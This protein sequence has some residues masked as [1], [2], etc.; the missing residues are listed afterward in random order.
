MSVGIEDHDVD[1]AVVVE[2]VEGHA[3]AAHLEFRQVAALVRDVDKLPVAHVPQH[4]IPATVRRS[5]VIQLDVV[6]EVAADD[7]EVAVAIVVEIN[8]TTAPGDVGQR[9]VAGP[10]GQ[11]HV[12]EQAAAPVLVQ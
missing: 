3:A 6:L 1:P 2:V 10:A 5:V 7:E 8:K 9:A 11:G 12:V 4:D